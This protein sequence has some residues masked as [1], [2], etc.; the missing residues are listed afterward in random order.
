MIEKERCN[1]TL[2]LGIG[3]GV[4]IQKEKQSKNYKKRGFWLDLSL[5]LHPNIEANDHDH[6]HDDEKDKHED[7]FRSKTIDDDDDDEEQRTNKSIT[8]NTCNNN[9]GSRKKLKLTNEQTTLLEASFNIRSTLST[10]QKQELAKKLKLLPRQIEVWFQN[11]RARTKLKQIEQE[12]ELLKKCC[13]TLNDENHKLKKEL[14]NVRCRS[15][16]FDHHH[17]P[18]TQPSLPFYIQYPVT[19]A[20]VVGEDKKTV[21]IMN[22]NM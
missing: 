22:D 19:K 10:G 5:P 7:S 15:L 16:K 11:R 14:Q 1:T 21:E 17:Q 4:V 12:H 6:K 18:M 9:D 20:M 2:G 8:S 13:E 3:T